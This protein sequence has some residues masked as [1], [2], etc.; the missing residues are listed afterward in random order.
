MTA[1]SQSRSDH[2]PESILQVLEHQVSVFRLL[3]EHECDELCV[4]DLV[5]IPTATTIDHMM[6]MMMMMM[7]HHVAHT[8]DR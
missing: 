6:M 7:M 5:T 1:V 4:H 8:A 3:C 2:L